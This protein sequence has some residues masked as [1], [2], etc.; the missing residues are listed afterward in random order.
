MLP[1]ELST[2][3][4]SLRPQL[5]RLVLSCTMEIDH[6]GEIVSYEINEGVIRSAERMTYT[7]VNAVL[8][9]DP[10]TRK[11]YATLVGHFDRMRDLAMILNRKRERRGSIDFDL[12]EPVIEFD[13]FGLMKSITRSERNV[14]HRLIE[15]FMLSANETVAHY[16][17]S[18]RIASLYRIHEKPDAKRVYD[19]EVIASTFGYS[20]G[21]GALPIHR[22]QMKADRRAAHGTGKRIR[23]IEVPKEVH[24]TPRMYQKLTAKIAGKP[25]E[26]ILSYLMLRSL[27]QARYSE[28]NLGHFALAAT[29][30]THFTSPI[31]R[32][33]DL[34][35]HRIL[36]EVLRDSPEQMH[37]EVPVGTPGNH[38]GEQNSS[39]ADQQLVEERPFRAVPRVSSRQTAADQSASPWSKRRDHTFRRESLT[40]LS[41]PIPLEELHDI[42]DESSQTERRADDAERELMEW[43]KVKFME[44]RIGEDFEGLIVSVTKFGLFVELTDLFVEGLVP[45]NTL[46]DDHYIY[47]ENTR[48]IIGQRSLRTYS[49][50]NRVRVLLDRV[51]PVEKKLQFAIWE[52]TARFPSRRRRR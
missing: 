25:E 52:E 31:R 22:L 42:A 24:I 2:D 30:Y 19:F 51:D 18:K 32:Y 14:A 1:L 20:L 27:K 26:R 5:D 16:L 48:Q 45:I 4:C 50:G 47:H 36:K 28:D 43:K 40:P 46:E 21:V 15:E 6:Q 17:E 9:G 13:E 7:A 44:R 41:G 37:G 12:P 8:E 39:L 49:F 29:A 33:P 10:A 23:E 34:I 38:A 11:R 3:I 35:V